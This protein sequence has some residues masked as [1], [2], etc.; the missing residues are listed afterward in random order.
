MASPEDGLPIAP[1]DGPVGQEQK[2]LVALNANLADLARGERPLL[3]RTFRG[4]IVH[5][6]AAGQ[7]CHAPA[8]GIASRVTEVVVGGSEG[9]RTTAKKFH[10]RAACVEAKK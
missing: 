5:P 4:G 9:R 1:H 6:M 3:D 10:D 2:R 8:T 7:Q